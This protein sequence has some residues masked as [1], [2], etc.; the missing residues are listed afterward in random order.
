VARFVS[1]TAAGYGCGPSHASPTPTDRTMQQI[2]DAMPWPLPLPDAV[3]RT[4]EDSIN[5]PVL[6]CLNVAAATAPD[7]HDAQNDPARDAPL[8]A[9]HKH[10]SPPPAHLSRKLSQLL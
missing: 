4:L 10:V 6:T 9:D 1:V 8:V 2:C 7:G 3:G 5:D